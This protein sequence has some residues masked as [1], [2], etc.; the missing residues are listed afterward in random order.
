MGCYLTCAD[1]MRQ[2]SNSLKGAKKE[3]LTTVMPDLQREGGV[4]FLLIANNGGM[5]RE[6]FKDTKWAMKQ[7]EEILG[8]CWSAERKR[9]GQEGDR[10]AWRQL[11]RTFLGCHRK[12]TYKEGARERGQ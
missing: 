1:G 6:R 2:R 5:R 9:A 12:R 8:R 7:E 11:Q 3:P 10:Q 4:R